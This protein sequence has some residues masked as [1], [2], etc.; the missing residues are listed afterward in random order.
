MSHIYMVVDIPYVE[1]QVQVKYW[2]LLHLV[3]GNT[4][5]STN[6]RGSGPAWTQ[7]GMGCSKAMQLAHGHMHMF[8]SANTTPATMAMY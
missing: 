7:I 8:T 3:A 4:S 1:S 5:T 2:W 6:C